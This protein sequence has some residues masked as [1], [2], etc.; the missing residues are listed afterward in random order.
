M[1]KI[2]RFLVSIP[3]AGGSYW[4]TLVGLGA[5][6]DILSGFPSIS[7]LIGFLWVAAQP[8]VFGVFVF[9]GEVIICYWLLGLVIKWRS[10]T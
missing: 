2:A 1:N 5:L 4:C 6:I 10:Q 7:A 8:F 9:V 3:L